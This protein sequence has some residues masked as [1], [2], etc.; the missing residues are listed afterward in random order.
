MK[1]HKKIKTQLVVRFRDIDAMGHVNNA[2]YLTYFEEGRKIFLTEVFGIREPGLYPFIM[3]KISCDYLRPISLDDSV[4][5]HVWVSEIGSKS[6]KFVYEL[7]DPDND[8]IVYARGSS[9]NVC[10][11]YE[12]KETIPISD[13]FK[14]KIIDYC[15][16]I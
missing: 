1:N 4:S 13:S 3:A 10:Y 2:V 16:N 8:E 14:E 9:V 6:F 5:L 12:K 15:E 11:D 7:L